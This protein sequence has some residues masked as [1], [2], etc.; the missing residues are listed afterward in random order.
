MISVILPTYNRATSL[1][2]AIDSVLCQTW[3]DFEL[4]VVDDGSTDHT[5]EVV[6]RVE[7][8]R[9]R[10][11][12]Y[13]EQRGASAARN[14]GINISRGDFIAFQDS[15]DEW[16]PEKLERQM[17]TFR[18]LPEAFGVVYTGFHRITKLGRDRTYPTLTARLVDWAP[19][20]KMKLQGNVH[21]SLLRGNFITTQT[22]MARRECFDLVGRF[23][24]R[25]PRFQDWDLWLR[26]SQLYQF[27]LIRQ[28]L[29]R[30]HSTPGSISNDED[31]LT[32]AFEVLLEK[33]L[34]G[35]QEDSELLAQY[36]YA[37]GDLACQRG[38]L[39]RGREDFQAAMRLSSANP[40]YRLAW[41]ASWLGQDFYCKA[42]RGPGYSYVSPAE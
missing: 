27:Q 36:H 1:R 41:A 12:S 16:L 30:V 11:I 19:F 21:F 6:E 24:E 15:D 20:S 33:H 14:E 10:F 28:S 40:V 22:V 4:I 38:E 3:G 9:L 25:L 29:V 18:R 39:R 35:S 32:R 23:D 42:V 17:E 5:H 7:D 31:A 37:M 2:W 26:F 34:T 13:P 8:E